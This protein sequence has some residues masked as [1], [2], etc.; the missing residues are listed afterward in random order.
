MEI[1]VVKSGDNV[2]DIA[3]MFGVSAESIIYDNQL[4]YPY[5]LAVGQALLIDT[6]GIRENRK[7]AVIRGFAY[8]FISRYVLEQ[9][10]PSMS[11]LAVFSYG[12]TREGEVIY[13]PLDD[14]FMIEAAYAFGALPILTLTPFDESG[15][16]SNELISAVIN[17]AEAVE[18]LIN[19]LIQVMIEK[20]FR[21]IDIDFE[22]IKAED[23]ETFVQFVARVT[24]RMHEQGFTVSVDL[25]PKTSADQPGLLYEGK[26]Y[27]AI[28]EIADSVLVMT[29]EWGYTYSMPMAV[30]PI[31]KVRQVLD[32]AVTEI[33]PER[34]NMGIP[35]YGY[36]WPLPYERGVTRATTIGNIEAIQIAIEND[37]Q[38]FFDELAQSPYFRYTK[39]GIEHEVWF[40]DPRSIRAKIELVYEYGLRGISYW[41][42]MRLF[43]ANWILVD[44]NFYVVKENE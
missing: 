18:T 37:S 39:D 26:D 3:Q 20:Q 36:D 2:D 27:R 21:G 25:A 4:V 38:I 44:Y 12:F 29:Y 24:E 33:P 10:L 35:N 42:I 1:Y 5:R 32:Y 22:Y 11:E 30:A 34:I 6:G 16:F 14:T 23:R 40:E 17:N 15:Q 13:P 7:A 19:N 41:Q 31:N 9:S 8:P 43:R 28:G